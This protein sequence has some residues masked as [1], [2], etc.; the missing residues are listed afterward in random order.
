MFYELEAK[1][2]IRIP[3]DLFGED[4]EN[5]LKEAL[6]KRFDGYISRDLGIVIGV[7][8]IISIGEG[9]V[10]PG[11]GGAYYDTQFKIITFKP[12]LQEVVL[13]KVSEIADFGAFLNLGPIDGMVHISQTMDDMVTFSKAKTLTGKDTK[14][15]LKVGDICRARII[16]VSLKDIANPKIGLTMRQHRLGAV[17]WIENTI[18]KGRK[19]KKEVVKETKK[20]SNNKNTIKTQEEDK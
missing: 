9:I 14:Q 3:P 1:G 2:Y 16:A 4:I 12:E 10:I 13:S 5:A 15:T 6:N 17:H 18:E 19:G 20:K 11:D 7:T 8:G